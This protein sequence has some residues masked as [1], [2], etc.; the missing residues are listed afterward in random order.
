MTW[1]YPWTTEPCDLCGCV[2]TLTRTKGRERRAE[3]LCPECAAGL[4]ARSE[5]DQLR[6]LLRPHEETLRRLADTDTDGGPA[7]Q[8]LADAVDGLP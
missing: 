2:H 3:E 8:E 4:V 6:A 7:E 5:R 1:L